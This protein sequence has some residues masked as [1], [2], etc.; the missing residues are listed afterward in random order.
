M[1]TEIK[2]PTSDNAKTQEFDPET[3][4]ITQTGE[5]K[6]LSKAGKWRRDN[7]GGWFYVKDRRAI[8]RMRY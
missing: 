2:T 3:M 6:K 4:F 5:I 7:P 8:N 1:E